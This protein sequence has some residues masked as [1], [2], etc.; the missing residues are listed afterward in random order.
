MIFRSHRFS[1]YWDTWCYH[2]GRTFFLYYL[3]TERGH[4]EGFGVAVLSDGVHW[5]DRGWAVRASDKMVG[6]LGTG[7]VWPDLR[8]HGRFLC[9][10][11]EWREDETGKAQQKILFASSDDLIRWEKLGDDEGLGARVILEIDDEFIECWTMGCPEGRTVRL[12]AKCSDVT[13][14]VAY[15]FEC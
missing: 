8:W 10:Y 3:I 9:N 5:E 14:A 11:S 13:S 1:A 6:Y 12:A 15:P 7:S 4:G 2:H